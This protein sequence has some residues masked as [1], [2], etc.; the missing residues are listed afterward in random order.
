MTLILDSLKL[1]RPPAAKAFKEQID[2]LYQ[3]A[4]AEEPKKS[5]L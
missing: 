1:K 3:E 5:K 2:A 4:L